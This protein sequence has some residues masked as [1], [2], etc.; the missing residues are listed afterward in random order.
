MEHESSA[1]D[2]ARANQE[3]PMVMYLVVRESLQM[4]MG[5]AC[6]QTAHAS[7]MLQLK[8]QKLL[9]ELTRDYPLGT[10]LPADLSVQINAYSRWLS[11]SFRKVVLTADDKEWEKI[12]SH[13]SIGQIVVVVDAGLTQVPSGSE[14]VIGCW[15]VLKSQQPKVLKRLQVLK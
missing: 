7:Q 5:K 14:T 2:A 11:E 1:A 8:F 10:P 15:P 12:K 6:A 13:F 4:T 3:D 9:M